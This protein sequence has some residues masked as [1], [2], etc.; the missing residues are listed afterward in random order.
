MM[1]RIVFFSLIIIACRLVFAEQDF[2]S[3]PEVLNMMYVLWKDSAFGKDPNRTERAAWII[4]DSIDG[5]RCIRWPRS[6]ERNREFWYGAVPHNTIAQIHT[7]TDHVDPR[8]ANKDIAFAK[9][10]GIPIYTISSGGIWVADRYGVVKKVYGPGWHK[11]LRNLQP[12]SKK[13]MTMRNMSTDKDLIQQKAWLLTFWPSS[14]AR[15]HLCIRCSCQ[16]AERLLR[17]KG[18]SAFEVF[19]ARLRFRLESLMG[20]L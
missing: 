20:C 13:A 17:T 2:V 12:A 8:P 3:H 18:G 14:P 4:H 11:N 19:S 7:H 9:R 6:G 5:F 15:S 1:R 16:I 10:I